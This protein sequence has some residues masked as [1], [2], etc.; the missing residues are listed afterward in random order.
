V[1]L[2]ETKHGVRISSLR[3]RVAEDWHARSV[4]G[5]RG[6]WR[7]AIT[8]VAEQIAGVGQFMRLQKVLRGKALA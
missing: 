1:S 7:L 5:R 6:G 8:G 4:I 2:D 3:S